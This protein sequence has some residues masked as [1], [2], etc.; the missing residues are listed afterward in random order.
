[1]KNTDRMNINESVGIVIPAY[2]P[3]MQTLE[4]YIID[5]ESIVNPET[6]RI[7]FDVPQQAN[8][9]RAEEVVDQV[10]IAERRRGKG[11]AIMDGLDALETDILVF[12]DADGSVPADS[13]TNILDQVKAEV[14]D[15]S[16]GSRRHPSSEILSH[17]TIIRRL[18]GDVFAFMA[19]GMLPTQCRDYQCGAK[20][21]RADAWDMIG[22][23]CYEPGFAWD[24]EFISVA[25]S[26][27]YNIAEV[28]VTWEDHPDSTV[29]PLAT[30]L[31]LAT[32]LVDVKRRTEAIRSSPRYHDIQMTDRSRLMRIGQDDD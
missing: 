11:A 23:H 17:Q 20:A 21:V 4:Q 28:P 25:G 19:R 5:L 2:E 27:G 13:L 9:T 18:L 3:D 22:D 12:T 24:L 31:E 32:A 30:V 15:I 14:A 8:V 16:I 26:L 10:N 29:A 6:I 1:M 7:E